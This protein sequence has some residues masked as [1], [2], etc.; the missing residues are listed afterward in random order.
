MEREHDVPGMQIASALY[1]RPKQIVTSNNFF[2]PRM[3][4]GLDCR[5]GELYVNNEDDGEESVR[6]G[7]STTK[8]ISN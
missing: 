8:N 5:S 3:A 6:I 2:S 1:G 7:T 4:Q